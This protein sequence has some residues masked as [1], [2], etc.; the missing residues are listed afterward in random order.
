MFCST[1]LN[2]FEIL[3]WIFEGR[4]GM[5]LFWL[6][7]IGNSLLYMGTPVPALVWLLYVHSLIFQNKKR[8]V[9]LVYV[10]VAIFLINASGTLLSWQTGWF[11]TIS[12]ENAYSRGPF[13]WL[14]AAI[15]YATLVFTLIVILANRRRQDLRVYRLLLAY[16]IL[17]IIGSALQL[18]IY[19][20]SLTWPLTALSS[21]LIYLHIQDYQLM[22]DHLTGT[23]NRR[24]F[25][26]MIAWRMRPG[27]PD[28]GFSVIAADID[29][30]K[31]I[32]D[33]YGHD[34][35]DQALKHVVSILRT[36]LRQQDAIAR[37]GG[38]EF[39]IIIQ[40]NRQ[41]AL[42]RAVTRIRQAF[43]AF[44][45]SSGEPYQLQISLGAVLFEP[46]RDVTADLLLKQADRRM[47]EEKIKTRMLIET[48]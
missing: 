7:R 48:P 29:H 22:T 6:N 30:F 4:P 38:D 36:C 39:Y 14:H 8:L 23:Y 37:M 34:A 25:E 40:T 3:G 43:D 21:M 46:K 47:Y 26:R 32:N 18:S 24:H 31:Q 45:Q 9:R 42:D 12:P 16:F 2:L 35:G 5:T 28:G 13:L 1:L 10:S 41:D 19:G 17:P 15:V 44:N 33:C 20:L 27:A 11:F